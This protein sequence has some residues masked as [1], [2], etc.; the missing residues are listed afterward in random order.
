MDYVHD[1]LADEG[2]M[3]C[4]NVVDDFTKE[5]IVIEVD[6]PISGVRVARG[7]DRIALCR[8]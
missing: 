3:R 2:R 1:G 7:W 6:I 4:L 5:R 8:P